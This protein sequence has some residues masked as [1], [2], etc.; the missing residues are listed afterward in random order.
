[1]AGDPSWSMGNTAWRN[2]ALLLDSHWGP[3]VLQSETGNARFRNK[4]F[5]LL[6]NGIG[7]WNKNKEYLEPGRS[8]SDVYFNPF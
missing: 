3:A 5:Y 2:K 4:R 8:I 6:F 7:Q 1:M